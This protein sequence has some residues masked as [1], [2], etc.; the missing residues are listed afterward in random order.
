[1]TSREDEAVARVRDEIKRWADTPWPKH[2]RIGS[3]GWVDGLTNRVFAALRSPAPAGREEV[4]R[5]IEEECDPCRDPRL[6]AVDRI[7]ALSDRRSEAGEESKP[8][9]T[10]PLESGPFL[11][12]S[13]L[14]GWSVGRRGTLARDR[15]F[16]FDR[17]I[18]PTHWRPLPQSPETAE[19][20]GR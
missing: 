3:K 11:L 9:E 2:S 7:L 4:A 5:I 19:G 17:Q 14:H 18:F 12:F 1:M 10:A 8:I 6:R 13:G 20:D 16:A 15:W